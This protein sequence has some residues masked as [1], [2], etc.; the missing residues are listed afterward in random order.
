MAVDEAREK[1]GPLS[2]AQLT[3]LYFCDLLSVNHQL[4]VEYL[5][6]NHVYNMS[7]ETFHITLGLFIVFDFR[8]KDK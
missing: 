6:T 4:T 7:F 5:A 3:A 2:V 1:I 8:C